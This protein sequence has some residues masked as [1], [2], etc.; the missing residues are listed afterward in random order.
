MVIFLK[1]IIRLFLCECL[2]VLS[3]KY[4]KIIVLK[5][6]VIKPSQYNDLSCEVTRSIQD[7]IDLTF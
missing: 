6:E 4:V 1:Q 3:Y 7:V 2:F 5:D